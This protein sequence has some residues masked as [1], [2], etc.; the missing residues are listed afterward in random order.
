MEETRKT[1]TPPPAV[2]RTWRSLL[3][4]RWHRSSWVVVVLV[5]VF[6]AFCNVP[7]Q[8]VTDID[9]NNWDLVNPLI[10]RTEHGWPLSWAR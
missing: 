5:L 8:L 3:T 9:F 10:R 2:P 4:G 1:A 6:L 7:G